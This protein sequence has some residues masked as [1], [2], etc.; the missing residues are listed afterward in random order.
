MIEPEIVEQ[1]MENLTDYSSIPISFE[2]RT[3]LDVQVIDQG[4]GGFVLSERKHETSYAKDYDAYDGL[5]PRGWAEQWDISNWGVISAFVNGSRVGGC[6]VAY[7]TPGI[8]MLEDRKDIAALWDLRVH[9]NYRSN[10][11]GSK[12]FQSAVTWARKRNC[13]FLKIETQNIN[14]P[15]CRLYAKH[16]CVLGLIN[17]YAYDEFP[18]EVELVWYKEL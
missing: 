3:I 17:R 13:R 16:G 15:A 4:L 7:D 8:H 18:D 11:V 14:V 1:S 9:P 6:V 2:V 10:G 12:L 5:G